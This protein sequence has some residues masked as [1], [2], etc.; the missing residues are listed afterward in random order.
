MQITYKSPKKD[1]IA[2]QIETLN[3]L[4]ELQDL[5]DSF[6]LTYAELAA[7]IAAGTLIPSAAY[8]I[9]DYQTVHTIPNTSDT[10]TGPLEPLL[11]TA[12]A[13]N[14]LAPV[15]FAPAFPDDIIFYNFSNDVDIVPGSTKGY[16]Y[17]RIDTKQNNDFPFDFRN[18]KF[19][20]WKVS[21]PTYSTSTTYARNQ[22][23]KHST[24]LGLY[25]SL[26][27]GNVNHA[28][29]D[30]KWWRLFEFSNE[31]FIAW[32]PTDFQ[33]PSA[34]PKLTVTADFWDYT[35]FTEEGYASSFNNVIKG[36][37]SANILSYCNNV[38]TGE[39]FNNN[40]INVGFTN[41]TISSYFDNNSIGIGFSNNT[42]GHQ[43]QKNLIAANFT[44]NSI[45]GEFYS[46]SIAPEFE[47]NSIGIQFFS[48][49]IG[50]SFK[51]N[52]TGS[53]FKVNSIGAA[54]QGNTISIN[55]YE[56][57]IGSSFI[58]NTLQYNFIR[59]LGTMTGVGV[60]SS[61]LY[62]NNSCLM[63]TDGE[64]TPFIITKDDGMSAI[65]TINLA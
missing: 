44:K 40:S 20:R 9:T 34:S 54:F 38:I 32:S 18:V 37:R 53:I 47:G 31:S 28:L 49:N 22:V 64:G 6:E 30:A 55:F 48:N 63:M 2:A 46:N 36:E 39:S 23:V 50:P 14:K 57:F 56:N 43:F 17:R 27:G 26:F 13:T 41:N 59:N 58:G 7:H 65:Y 60:T 62:T 45:G 25:V 1:R 5:S 16:I 10:N 35:M 12:T 19:R 21:Q 24:N 4:L 29:T 15:A 42:I 11:V 61:P 3:A 8:L 52:S 33:I 51:N